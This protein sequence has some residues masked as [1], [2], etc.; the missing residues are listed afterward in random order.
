MQ[1]GKGLKPVAFNL[2]VNIV[3]TCT[4]PPRACT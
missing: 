2:W 3:S 4:T 1:G